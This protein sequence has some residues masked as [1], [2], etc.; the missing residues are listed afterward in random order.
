MKVTQA[1]EVINEMQNQFFGTEQITP[2]TGEQEIVDLGNKFDSLDLLDKY[3]KAL[4]NHI[5]RVIFDTRVYSGQAPSVYM[6][7]TEYGSIVEKI[8]AEV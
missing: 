6:D 7:G 3:V 2:I 4:V 5:G 8:R 1:Y